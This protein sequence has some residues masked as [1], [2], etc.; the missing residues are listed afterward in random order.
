MKAMS[1]LQGSS[2]QKSLNKFTVCRG[3]SALLLAVGGAMLILSL[4]AALLFGSINISLSE[5]LAALIDGDV[6]NASLRIFIYSRIPRAIS[7]LLSGSALA[8]SGVIIQAVLENP[9][10]A[11]NIIGVN[12][13]AGFSAIFLMALFP[14]AVGLLP[15]AAFL[16]AM[17]ACL[18]IY[19]IASR[20]GAGKITITLVGIA[21]GS[22]L[23][24]GINT[25]K[26]IFPDTVYDAN[27]FLIGGLS[28]VN[29]AKLSPAC[30]IILGGILCAFFLA[31]KVDVLTL[32]EESATGLGLN[33]RLSRFILLILASALAGAAVSFAGLLGFIGLIVPHI[34]RRLVGNRHSL[35]IP[36]S[37][38]GG[39]TL[40]LIC[41]L[42][43]RLI[44]APYEIPVG[45]TLSL[46]GGPFFIALVLTQRRRGV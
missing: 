28:G 14:S 40:V 16:G 18:V 37:A 7:A 33:V 5:A 41:D 42:L 20:T 15:I 11:P 3:R 39:G 17:A 46:L 38:M 32:G 31:R 4:V 12:A 2:S 45:I 9:M 22:I 23:T 26:T 19:F 30:Y 21:V 27:S 29:Y 13:G 43:S 36:M 25:V 35:L 10:A 8:V 24:A 44:F 6:K 1:I 34:M